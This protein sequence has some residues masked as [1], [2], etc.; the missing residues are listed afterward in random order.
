MKKNLLVSMILLISM[1]LSGQSFNAPAVKV[2]PESDPGQK[3]YTLTGLRHGVS[4]FPKVKLAHVQYEAGEVLTFDKYH[5]SIVIYAWM[6][7]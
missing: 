1:T 7:R 6:G 2:F 5:S 3:N 4:Y